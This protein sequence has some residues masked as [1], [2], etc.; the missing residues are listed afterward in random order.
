MPFNGEIACKD[1]IEL[2][3]EKLDGIASIGLGFGIAIIV[4]ISVFTIGIN[5]EL[6]N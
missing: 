1:I 6:N 5:K 3:V 4:L 2:E